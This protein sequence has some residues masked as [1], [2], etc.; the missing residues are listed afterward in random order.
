MRFLS[1]WIY[2]HWLPLAATVVPL[3]FLMALQ[4]GSLAVQQ[5][6][7]GSLC[8]IGIFLAL[9]TVI[10]LPS[11]F[12]LSTADSG[13]KVKNAVYGMGSFFVLI[14]ALIAFTSAAFT[15]EDIRSFVGQ[16]SVA[17]WTNAF[18]I[19]TLIVYGFGVASATYIKDHVRR[20]EEASE[21]E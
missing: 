18:A 1:F 3:V 2:Q 17:N 21:L 7:T 19:T 20:Y 10:D 15:V 12:K 14:Y 5:L 16:N 6:A 9:A 11:E 8:L 13:E 4:Q